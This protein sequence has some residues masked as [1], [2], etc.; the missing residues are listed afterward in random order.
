MLVESLYLLF[1]YFS[2]ILLARSIRAVN[3][4][5]L[6]TDIV[7]LR[8]PSQSS[9]ALSSS[10][11]TSSQVNASTPNEYSVQC[12]GSQ[13]GYNPDLVDCED[14]LSH[15][16]TGRVLVEFRQRDG[17]AA[18]GVVTLPYRLMGGM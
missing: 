14:A 17:A 18:H 5:T 3:D 11:A 16:M 9:S 2:A 8:I 7:D 1:A 10:N 12:D 15:Q 6:Q 13:Y 4:E